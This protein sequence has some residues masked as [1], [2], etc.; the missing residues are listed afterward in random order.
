[1]EGKRIVVC[2]PRWNTRDEEEQKRKRDVERRKSQQHAR[3]DRNVPPLIFED[4]S[5]CVFPSPFIM[6]GIE[7]GR[8]R[9]RREREESSTECNFCGQKFNS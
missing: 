1:M 8:K 4:S 3:H 7:E 6:C 5:A 9:R 2:R